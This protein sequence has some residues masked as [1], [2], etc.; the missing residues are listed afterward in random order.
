VMNTGQ[1]FTLEIMSRRVLPVLLL[2]SFIILHAQRPV[3]ELWGMR[4]HDDAKVLSQATIQELESQLKQ[5]E[6]ST[7]NQIAVLIIPSLDGEVLEDYALKVAEKWQLG[8]KGR[9]NGVLLLVAINDKKMRIEV[10]Y[11]LEGALPDIT[12]NQI[13][14]NEISPHFR[15]GDFDGGIK[16]GV[17]GI[18]RAIGGEYASDADF[19][20]L[21]MGIPI[22]AGFFVFGILGLFTL[23][24]LL[25]KGGPTWFLYVFLIPFYAA[26]PAALYGWNT[27]KYI[28]LGYVVG[29]PV[30]KII[31]NMMGWSK[32]QGSGSGG[33]SGGGWSSSGGWSSG[34]GGGWSSGGGFSGGGGSFGGG[35]SS[36]SW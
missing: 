15:R 31:F 14:R 24:G 10:G 33:G 28:L 25:T 13:I 1:F 30:L 34:G 32:L 11:G 2:L 16:A 12:C 8:K 20:D 9:D 4:V 7:T 35:G 3:P 17:E 29:F 6:D 19:G 23:I 27:G 5:F 26:F 21:D 36:G 18:T 22:W